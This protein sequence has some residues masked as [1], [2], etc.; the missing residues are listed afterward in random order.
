MLP[1][2]G[3]RKWNKK[4]GYK[5]LE[6]K[7][8]EPTHPLHAYIR[9]VNLINDVLNKASRREWEWECEL[10]LLVRFPVRIRG[11][12]PSQMEKPDNG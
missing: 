8:G 5:V 2:I 6:D 11:I 10:D 12:I 9:H 3:E 4:R 7:K 1:E